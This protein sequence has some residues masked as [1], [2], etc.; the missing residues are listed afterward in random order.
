MYRKQSKNIVLRARV[1][2]LLLC[3]Y[4]V[5]RTLVKI[6]RRWL[7]RLLLWEYLFLSTLLAA[8]APWT[9]SKA[10]YLLKQEALLYVTFQAFKS[11]F[12]NCAV[13]NTCR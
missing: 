4:C 8:F 12:K 13:V 10:V 1:L 7:R 3:A 9:I 5:Y 11:R 6:A 2:R